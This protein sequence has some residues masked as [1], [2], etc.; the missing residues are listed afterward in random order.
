MAYSDQALRPASL[1]Y[2]DGAHQGH[3]VAQFT[4]LGSLADLRAAGL[5]AGGFIFGRAVAPGPAPRGRAQPRSGPAVE[6]AGA[7]TDLPSLGDDA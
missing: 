1:L 5:T 3:V 6:P 4:K 7:V 2:A